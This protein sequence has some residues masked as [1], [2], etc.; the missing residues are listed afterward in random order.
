M[1]DIFGR[2]RHLHGQVFVAPEGALAPVT[3]ASGR[4]DFYQVD[5]LGKGSVPRRRCVGEVLRAL[6]AP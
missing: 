1:Y 4:F 6:K 2:E 3:A 5:Y